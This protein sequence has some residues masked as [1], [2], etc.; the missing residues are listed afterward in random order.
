MLK[1]TLFVFAFIVGVFV[2][3]F[4]KPIIEG[5][6]ER[7]HRDSRPPLGKI[8]SAMGPAR[9]KGPMDLEPREVSNG[10][11][12]RSQDVLE[13]TAPTIISFMNG[14]KVELQTGTQIFFES[15][16][17]IYVTFRR[18]DFKLLE[19]SKTTEEVLFILN[20]Q[21]INPE[22]RAGILPLRV[23]EL[24]PSDSA[25]DAAK[26]DSNYLSDE[27]ISAQIANL[28][29]AFAKCYA[30]AL[31]QEP[32]AKGFVHLSFLI[33][34]D[35]KVSQTKILKTDITNTAME[36]CLLKVINRIKFRSFEGDPLLVNY[37][38]QFE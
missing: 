9:L 30:L 35:G 34:N 16:P 20:G 14:L 31:R 5:M 1:Q 11:L 23:Q 24:K 15:I 3:I 10:H 32:E 22:G 26:K 38:L 21:V 36:T 27:Y 33:E 28:R 8:E 18:G 29:S 2:I 13:T 25:Q 4:H 6:R 17:N 37:P 19:K 12:V 7:L